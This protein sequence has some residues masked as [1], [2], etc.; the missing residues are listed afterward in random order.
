VFF[1]LASGRIL[2]LSLPVIR[3][4]NQGNGGGAS[5]VNNASR[6]MILPLELLA[7]GSAIAIFPALS[8]LAARGETEEVRRQ[9]SGVLRRTLKLLLIATV[10]LLVL[11]SPLVFLL[12]RYGKF[13]VADANFTAQVLQISALSLPAL[14]AQQL[15]A[16]GF[17]A[18]GDNATPVK[19]GLGAMALFGVLALV[20]HF[21][22]WGSLGI[23]GASVMSICVLAAVLWKE[24][25][26]KLSDL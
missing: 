8:Q 5:A 13:S 6:L 3:A 2:A 23:T 12:L 22:H 4:A 1:G 25:K 20:S 19:A 11:A 17:F 21:S 18:L 24:L 10:A 26:K 9:L 14:G 16:R 15:L 7:S